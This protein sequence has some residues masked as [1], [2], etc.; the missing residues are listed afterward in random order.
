MSDKAKNEFDNSDITNYKEI[1]FDADAQV[2]V[3][4][5]AH[6]QIV[7]CNSKALQFFK[8]SSLEELI[9][10]YSRS[11]YAIQLDGQ[12]SIDYLMEKFD[13]AEKNGVSE[14]ELS[15]VIVEDI[16]VPL[17]VII[18][19][20]PYQE[21]YIFL[22]SGY[23]FTDFKN[24]EIKAERQ[25]TYLGV[26]N[27]IGKILL[28]SKYEGFSE[29]M[30]QVIGLVGTAFNASK[31]SITIISSNDSFAAY[32]YKYCW[33]RNTEADNKS[34]D[35]SMDIPEKWMN[36]LSEGK[37][38]YKLLSER[39]GEDF[40]FLEKHGIKSVVIAPIIIREELWGYIELLYEKFERLFYD[41]GMN[42]I[43]GVANLLV[44][45][46][47]NTESISLLMKYN[48]SNK[49]ML[50]S[51]PFNTIMFDEH[52][53]ILD[54][55]L[56]AINYFDVA[57]SKD[58]SKELPTILNRLTPEYQPSGRKSIPFSERLKTA[59]L[60]GDC[61][62]ETTFISDGKELHFDTIMK[63]VIYDGRD[64][65]VTYMFDLT[66]QKEIQYD[67]KYHDDLLTALSKMANLLLTADVIE[68]ETTL[69]N[70]AFESIG[71]ATEVDRVYV[72][73]NHVGDDERLY[74]SQIV[75]WSP[76]AESVQ[77]GELA[78]DIAF[79][80]VLPVWRE[81]LL[82]GISVNTI[83]KDAD[84]AVQR[85]LSPQGVV[86]VLLVPIFLQE[87]F[88]GFI[89]FDDCHNE[90]KFTNVEEAVLRI[91]GFM[92]MVINDTIQN[93][94]AINLLAEREAALISAQTKSNF[95][96]NMSH[97]IRTPLN[98][99][100]G[101]AELIMHEDTSDSVSA[102]ATD[103]RN[104]CRGL[105]AIIND[106]LDISKIESGKLEITKTKY[107]I[108]SLLM[109]VV[110]IIKTRTDN[111]H[112]ALIVNID[113][114]IPD[115]LIG[116]EL[117][118]KQI[119][120]N[121]LGNAVKYT[122]EG[123]IT[124]AVE[125]RKEGDAYRLS[126]A[127]TDTG[128]G[129]KEEDMEKV[130]V[131]FEQI[132]TTKNR[133]IEGTGLGLPISRQLAE[134]MDGFLEMKSEYG[135]GSTFTFN[136]L[137]EVADYT[138]IAS[139][140]NAE[141][142]FVLIFENRDAHLASL[143]FSI[144]S[145]GC[146]YEVCTNRS[147]MLERLSNKK[148]DYIFVSILYIENI[149]EV[150]KQKQPDA[151]IVVLSGEGKQYDMDGIQSI[152]MPINSLQLASI[153]NDE[154]ENYKGS[155]GDILGASII[156]PDANVLVVDDNIVNLKVGIGLLD[157]YMIKADSASSGKRAIEM[158]QEKDYDIVFMDYM[159][160]EMDGIDTTVAIRKLGSK[161]E[162]LPIIALTANA[163]GGVKEM[164]IAEGLNDYL[165]KPIAL[166]KLSMI[167]RK[168][169]PEEKQLRQAGTKIIDSAHFE[170]EGLDI[171]N[172]IINAGGSSE[173]Y[174]EILEIYAADNER[175][176]VE[177]EN[178]FRNGNI[179]A[180]TTCVHAIKSASANVGAEEIS[181][182]ALKLEEAGKI[183]DIETIDANLW[184]FLE[185]LRVLL[186]DIREFL[187]SIQ[188][189][190]VIPEKDADSDVLK[191]A[192]EGMIL[193]MDD[194]DIDSVEEIAS[195]LG[196]YLWDDEIIECI[197]NIRDAINVFDYDAIGAAIK[198]LKAFCFET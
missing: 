180:F 164:F 116:D 61:R 108:S 165:P 140:E 20:I 71:I 85:Q 34:S 22:A 160:P 142:I 32:P 9:E 50:D 8:V 179:K 38:V 86:S 163:V 135:V 198:K 88:W 187:D 130:F 4:F 156:A 189:K 171:E 69:L 42:S 10:L 44:S 158:V 79:D 87:K 55:N 139:V 56:S 67:L 109:D 149:L 151:K 73:K 147:E 107:H 94:V 172:G 3:I 18:N 113:S 72:W 118:T 183:N 166:A 161:Y 46:V 25:A 100:L 16:P 102:H 175:R 110:S 5:D 148:C 75:E 2:K 170:I 23:D 19:R 83:V 28:S 168:W 120:I 129:I 27:Q 57:D 184:T 176:Q 150:A 186:T 101:M 24:I 40:I 196:V 39:E 45:H 11:D 136:I 93:E 89:G 15:I 62:F 81:T 115:E 82:K 63:R 41:F 194:L 144:K 74:T 65:V 104:A 97:E 190:A 66:E 29:P 92:A 124:L 134:M 153:F 112:L 7:Y 122:H 169:L 119:L 177:L 51:N 174:K 117:R 185:L 43:A 195:A 96:A 17:N 132:D 197:S 30:K 103:I 35:Y 143:E 152:S 155:S 154:L 133:N 145:L 78:V 193:Y 99:I 6:R 141:D 21:S 131:L 70:K 47:I 49:T 33:Q 159:M 52:A 181:I 173:D 12:N 123:H 13:E 60:Q 98:A 105:V 182:N 146:H 1:T 188:K 128:I 178:Y 138:P 14:F 157:I 126:F 53:N 59:F 36:D 127:V 125:G 37:L 80:D 26:L 95:L 76:Y 54:I 137:Q 192:V 162:N 106:V 68:W 77:G 90:R 114:N 91:S 58:L 64:A 31:A 48:T 121:I 191:K 111:K 84:P 167:L